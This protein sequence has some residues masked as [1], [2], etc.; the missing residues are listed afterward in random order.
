[1]PPD[2]KPSRWKIIVGYVA[3]SLFSLIFCLYLTF[4]YDAVKQRVQSEANSAGLYVTIGSLGPGF[5]GI[6]ASNVR[7]SKKAA[8]NADKPP[9]ALE[10]K[11][12]S[13]RPTLF[14]PGVSVKANAL[15]GS[16]KVQVGGMSDISL[17][18]EFDDLDLS[19]GNLKGFS[20]VD[21]AGKV[22]GELAMEIPRAMIGNSKIAEPD[23][24]AASGSANLELTGVNVN[25]GTISV[26]IAMYGPE[27]TPI[28]LP[29][30]AVGDLE[31][32]IKFEKGAGTFE[33]LSVKGPGLEVNGSGTLKLAKRMEYAEP[34]IELKMKFEPAFT[35]SLGVYGAGLSMLQSDPKDPNW[36]IARLSGYLGRPTFK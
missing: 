29:K 27:P 3:F 28:D 7:V 11:S 8:D 14:P 21:L 5:S 16:A 9:E 1:M 30:I 12:V 15:G 18:A 32:K 22:N 31:T 25:G 36:K 2:K 34:N 23:L 13:V 4:P 33:K 20:G 26:A 35:S 19:Q 24:G 6:T 17:R 10:L